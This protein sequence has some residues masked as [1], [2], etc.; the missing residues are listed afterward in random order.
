MGIL[1]PIAEALN[2]LFFSILAG[3]T[4]LLFVPQAY[5]PKISVPKPVLL[6]ST[7]GIILCSLA[8]SLRAASYFSDGSFLE[9]L[10]TVISTF[11]IGKSWLVIGFAATFFWMTIYVEGNRFLKLFWLLILV[12]AA[13]WA[14]HVASLDFKWGFPLH[15]VHFLAVILWTGIV[16][17]AGWFSSEPGSW[18][19][20]LRWFTPFAAASLVLIGLSG[21][22][23][24]TFVI[25]KGQ[26]L[27][28]WALPYG[29]ILLL[30][31]ISI[32]PVLL[33]AFMNGILA[34]KLA[35]SDFNPLP[36]LKMEGLGIFIIFSFT[37]IL[38]TLSPPHESALINSVPPWITRVTGDTPGFPLT[39]SWDLSLSG[40][41]LGAMAILFA[42]LVLISF[43]KRDKPL[44]A[45]MFGLGLIVSTY[46]ALMFNI[47]L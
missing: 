31:H 15:S 20:F 28:S 22:L 41:L 39:V 7:L 4:A 32:I 26:Y 44:I 38:G 37:A 12:S 11:T 13:G 1:V 30:K 23:L 19:R 24:M 9:T 27:H 8:P 43:L 16:I 5:K 36:W 33:F 40:I 35:V 6:L 46:L 2:Y 34:R 18:Q 47:Q 3:H 21:F 14:S 29:Q 42:A 10:L 25:N 17:L 45:F